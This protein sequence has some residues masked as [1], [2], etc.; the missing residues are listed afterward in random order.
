MWGRLDIDGDAARAVDTLANGGLALIP[1]DLGYAIVGSTPEALHKSFIAKGRA[2]HKKHGMLGNWDLHRE[3]HVVDQRA[4]EILE[5][6][7]LDFGLP[8]GIVAPFRRD[9]P[10]L[11]KYDDETLTTCTHKGT[12]GMLVNNGPLY[13]AS[14]RLGHQRSIALLGSSANL[15]GT[16]PKFRLED[17]QKPL[18]D[19]ATIEFDYGLAKFHLYRRSSTMIDVSTMQIIRIGACYDVI[20]TILRERFGFNNLPIDPGLEALPSGHLD[21]EQTR[22]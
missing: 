20:A 5:T 22:Y 15:S 10:I 19:A 8:V 1:G 6:L 9:H 11:R 3:L 17:V 14:T 12:L 18:R 13:E 4:R 7:A 2:A 21:P 16:G